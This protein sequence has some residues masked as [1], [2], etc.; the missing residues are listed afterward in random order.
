MGL[1]K[2]DAARAAGGHSVL[3]AVMSLDELFLEDLG[4][5]TLFQH[6]LIPLLFRQPN[7]PPGIQLVP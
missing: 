2:L 5:V 6:P 4:V 1:A 3:L 7:L